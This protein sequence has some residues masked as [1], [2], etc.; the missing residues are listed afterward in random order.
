MARRPLVPI[1]LSVFS[2]QNNDKKRLASFERQN[3]VLWLVS[4]F[5]AISLVSYGCGNGKMVER[6]GTVAN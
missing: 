5:L 6:A 1:F 4:Y 3:L 2:S